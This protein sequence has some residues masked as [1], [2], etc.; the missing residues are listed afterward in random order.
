METRAMKRRLTI[1]M[2][3]GS[4]RLRGISET[5]PSE[6]TRR[7]EI[8]VGKAALNRWW[9]AWAESLAFLN[10]DCEIRKPSLSCSNE[11]LKK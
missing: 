9:L 8:I 10:Y 1:D 2:L 5:C 6:E 3:D 11:Y 7:G 4:T